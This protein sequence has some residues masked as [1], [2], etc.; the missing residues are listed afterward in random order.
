[1]EI[2]LESQ[3]LEPLIGLLTFLGQKLGPKKL[4]SNEFIPLLDNQLVAKIS[5]E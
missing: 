4:Q 5:E 1:L 2:R 3:S